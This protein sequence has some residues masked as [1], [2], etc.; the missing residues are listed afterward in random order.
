MRLPQVQRNGGATE[1]RDRY[2]ESEPL[3][4]AEKETERQKRP[5]LF[6][7]N[8]GGFGLSVHDKTDD[9]HWFY[10]EEMYRQG[11]AHGDA[12]N[13]KPLQHDR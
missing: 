13:N 10:E 8:T 2:D 6:G 3:A 9:I 5:L 12:Y 11:D 7:N 1:Q 4:M